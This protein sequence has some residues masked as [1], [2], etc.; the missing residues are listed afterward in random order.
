MSRAE[1]IRKRWLKALK[2]QHEEEMKPVLEIYEKI[3]DEFEKRL[4]AGRFT[5]VTVTFSEMSFKIDSIEANNKIVYSFKNGYNSNTVNGI[6]SN[7]DKLFNETEGYTSE[8]KE[9]LKMFPILD[10]YINNE[11]KEE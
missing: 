3:L 2:K 6:F 10:I 1:E 4:E 9:I 11:E 5:G 8:M 7:L